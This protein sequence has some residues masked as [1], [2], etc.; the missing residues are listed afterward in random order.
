MVT[1]R[2][3]LVG[4]PADQGGLQQAAAVLRPAGPKRAGEESDDDAGIAEPWAVSVAAFAI[5]NGRIAFTD[6]S[7]QP[8]A[9]LGIENLSLQLSDIDNREGTGMPLSLKFN[10]QEGGNAGFEG[11]A[12]LL[13]AV[14]L[15]GSASASGV[16]LSLAQSYVQQSL[17]LSIEGGALQ[18]AAEFSL[19]PQGEFQA[20]GELSVEMLDVL[21]TSED[22]RLVTWEHM[23]IDRFELDSASA[24]ARVSSVR[25]TYP[26][27]RIHIREDLSTNVGDVLAGAGVE[28]PAAG[29]EESTAWSFVLGGIAIIGSWLPF[30]WYVSDRAASAWCFARLASTR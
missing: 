12:V 6:R 13:P 15:S 16:P 2:Y 30:R 22:L 19:D 28:T 25:F 29:P 9:S 14:S 26:Y 1:A 18:A 21:D 11:N 5:E 24:S 23:D 3:G 17:A 20:A 8:N 27:G 10:L 4:K 7:I